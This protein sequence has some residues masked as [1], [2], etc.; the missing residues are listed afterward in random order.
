VTRPLPEE[1]LILTYRETI[2]P[3]YAYVSRRVGGDY[4]LAEDLVQET[5]MRALGA[6]PAR[7]VPDEPLAWLIRV[8]RNVLVSHFRRVRPEP[9]DPATLDLE[10]ERFSP[11][12]PDAAA[13]IGWGLARLGRRHA[14]ILEAFYFEG[15]PVRAIASERSLSERAVEGRLRRARAKLKKKIEPVVARRTNHAA[16]TRTP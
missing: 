5:W 10:D 16:Q 13:V 7:G 2:R 1:D 11:E 12:G 8:A 3:L 9:V 4:G 6:W 15:K 14:E